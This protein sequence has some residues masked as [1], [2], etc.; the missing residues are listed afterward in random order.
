MGL[1]E[2]WRQGMGGKDTGAAI[3]GKD[4]YLVEG[5]KMWHT[6]Q[7]AEETIETFSVSYFWK[8]FHFLSFIL[9]SEKDESGL[10]GGNLSTQVLFSLTLYQY[11][12]YRLLLR[13]WANNLYGSEEQPTGGN[14]CHKLTFSLAS[15]LSPGQ[16]YMSAVMWH[17]LHWL[18]VSV[19]FSLDY[20][21][22]HKQMITRLPPN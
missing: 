2:W 16:Q 4:G 12:W 8:F 13:F 21:I 11:W 5:E 18:Q 22:I 14:C 20:K 6:D 15:S 3:S 17:C 9:M 10:E 7:E 1:W 19:E